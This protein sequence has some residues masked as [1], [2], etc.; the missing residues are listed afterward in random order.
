[1]R[2]PAPRFKYSALSTAVFAAVL[3][4]PLSVAFAQDVSADSKKDP[5]TQK[6]VVTGS[7]IPQTAKETFQ[8]ITVI[9]ADDIKARAFNSVEEVLAASNMATGGVQ[10]NQSS[11]SFTQGAQTVSLFGLPSGYIKFLIDGRPMSNYPALYNGTDVF[12]NISGIPVD[13]VDRIE[14]LPGGQSS[15]YG[16]DAIAGVINII[17]KKQLDGVQ[18]GVRKGMYSLGGGNSTRLSLADGFSAV[19]DR[20]NVVAGVQYEKNDP[21]WGYQRAL[22]RQYNQ[23]SY[24]PTTGAHNTPLASRDFLVNGYTNFGGYFGNGTTPHY[25]YVSLDK[26]GVNCDAVTGLFGGTEAQQT[27]AGSSYGTYCGSYSTP[28]Y[29]TLQNGNTS[30]EGYAHGSFDVNENVQVYA[31]LLLARTKSTYQV[32]ANYT[33]WGTQADFGYFYDPNLDGLLNLQRAFAPEDF[34]SGGFNNATDSSIENSYNGTIGVSGTIGKSDWDYDVNFS[35]AQDRLQERSWVR[36]KDK[37]DQ[38]FIDHVLGP[39]QGY[40]PYYGAYPV[41]TPNY[42]AFYQPISAADMAAMT[43]QITTHSSTYDE[44]VRGQVTNASLFSLPGGKAG[45]ALALE[46]GKSGWK[47]NPDPALSTGGPDGKG[48]VWGQTSTG[49]SAGDRTRYAATSELRLPVVKQFT[50]TAS[51]RYDSFTSSSHTISKPTYALGF[52]LRPVEEVLLRGKYGTAF[53][54]PSL[55][56]L[57]QSASGYYQPGT[58]DYWQ[59]YKTSGVTPDQAADQC[60]AKYTSLDPLN[61]SSGNLALKPINAK[62]WNLGAVLAP[63]KRMSL[64]V[65]YYSWDI[66]DEVTLQSYDQILRQEYRCRAGL[67][68]ITSALCVATL[69]QVTRTAAGNLSGVFTPDINVSREKER[70]LTVAFQNG[71]SIGEFGDVTFGFDYTHILSHKQQI[72]AGDDY[73]NLLTNP[74]YSSDPASKT[75]VMFGWSKDK[76]KAAVYANWIGETPNYV[77][78]NSASGDYSAPGAGKL[79]GHTTFNASVSAEVMKGLTLSVMVNNVFNTMP[80]VD[81]YY[82]ATSGAPYN[83]YNFNPYGRE[84]LFEVHYAFGQKH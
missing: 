52:E 31:D 27:R 69:A 29:R 22:T 67:D 63:A 15:L 8:P 16:S 6:V 23:N 49:G 78:T 46:W 79:P 81:S 26:L 35:R 34:G 84:F 73:I 21:I 24:N 58:V 14:I 61:T 7:L 9:T 64:S 37:M 45:L 47:Y 33:W 25:G 1:M 43:G 68:D 65:D 66:K 74:Y 70:A 5:D 4:Q 71:A 28:G 62:V 75:Q 59:C 80:P 56:N 11:A 38:Y 40:D 17:L 3:A 13:L 53:K 10:G 76:L 60:P 48:N 30:S 82:P 32:G 2:R 12:N 20:L 18:V 72:Y 83:S 77:A 19:N 44:Q 54:A 55:A 50:V 57:Y 39:Q 42:A 41:Y 51:G 36:W